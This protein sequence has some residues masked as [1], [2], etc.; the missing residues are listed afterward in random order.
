[1]GRVIFGD[2]EAAAGLFVKPVHDTRP[3]HAADAAEL[4]AAMVQ[5]RVDQ[6]AL[7]VPGGRMY[8]HA[9][10]LVEDKQVVVFEQYVQRDLL[11]SGGG[12][13][14]F[15]P[16]DFDLFPGARRMRGFDR[17][18]IQANVTLLDQ[19]LNRAARDRRES[20]AQEGIQ[21][22]VRQ[23]LLHHDDAF[24]AGG[25]AFAH[26][27][28]RGALAWGADNTR[29]SKRPAANIPMLNT[30]AGVACPPR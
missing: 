17:F 10:R 26:D 20:R 27:F 23:R 14:G 18:A 16:V 4:S 29:Q 3:R 6:R 25:H 12:G 15:R 30:C 2:D 24:V 5:Q 21:P 28:G 13:L 19:P 8:D 11:R 22:F 9:G 7:L 1:M